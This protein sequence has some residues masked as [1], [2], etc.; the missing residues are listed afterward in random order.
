MKEPHL[1]ALISQSNTKF[2]RP[3]HRFSTK[4]RGRHEKLEDQSFKNNLRKRYR[5][6]VQKPVIPS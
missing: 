6:L 2:S 1:S 3:D 5:T 4:E